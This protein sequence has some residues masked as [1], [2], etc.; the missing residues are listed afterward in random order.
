MS[1]LPKHAY[2]DESVPEDE[3]TWAIDRGV[4]IVDT[5]KLLRHPKVRGQIAKAREIM[6]RIRAEKAAKQ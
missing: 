2:T 5:H 3:R 1:K 6:A 4:I